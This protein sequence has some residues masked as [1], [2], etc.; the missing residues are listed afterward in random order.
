MFKYVGQNSSAAMV[1][2]KRSA[3]VAPQVNLASP[4]H[5]GNE[6]PPWVRNLEQ[7]SPEVQNRKGGIVTIVLYLFHEK[8]KV[9]YFF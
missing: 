5:T 3:G 1:V 6:T 2:A 4:L 7:T 8:S 9:S